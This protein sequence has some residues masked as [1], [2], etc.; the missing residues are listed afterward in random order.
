MN[1]KRM[2]K[3]PQ[4]I[5]ENARYAI[6]GLILFTVLN[7]VLYYT[8][9][10]TYYVA[11]VFLSYFLVAMLENAAGLVLAALVL[12][13]YVLCFFLSKKKYAWMI[14][15]LVLVCIDTLVLL[16]LLLAFGVVGAFALDI[17]FHILAIVMLAI[18]VKNGKAALG[19][20]AA[21]DP[22]HPAE[23]AAD[24][25]AVSD[26]Y[27]PVETAAGAASDPYHPAETAE[28]NVPQNGA[29]APFSEMTCLASVSE[30]GKRFGMAGE[31]TLRFYENEVVLGTVSMAKTL[32]VGSFF[33]SP[34]EK[35]RFAYSD[36]A[37]VYY[38][39][40][41]ERNVR[42]DLRDGRAIA[43]ELNRNNKQRFIDLFA[44]HGV[45]IEPFAQQ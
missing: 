11:T 4:R 28:R 9:S 23:T 26:P 33:S 25:A 12:A 22:Y 17:L 19:A 42:I 39:R 45:A 35:A 36:I 7:I 41:N 38:A 20:G 14:V 21:S 6:L 40:K 2:A 31:G 43:M 30:D 37:R 1:N 18:G 16:L 15:A 27:H 32:L 5:Y 10:D 13:P 24:A 44:A 8:G 29:E 34:T 3:S